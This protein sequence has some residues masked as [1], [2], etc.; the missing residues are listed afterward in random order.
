MT[1]TH[2]LIDWRKADGIG[3]GCDAENSYT[4][5]QKPHEIRIRFDAQ[6]EGQR[7]VWIEL[8]GDNIIVHCYDPCHD[9]PLNV[10]IEPDDITVWD[11]R[12][13]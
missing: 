2:T 4:I 10:V 7:E 1:D 11:E 3:P 12:N 5:E 13:G 9:E 6:H 8:E